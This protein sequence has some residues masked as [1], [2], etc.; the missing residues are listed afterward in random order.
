MP[1]TSFVSNLIPKDVQGDYFYHF[2]GRSVFVSKGQF[3]YPINIDFRSTPIEIKYKNV[4]F[5]RD[6]IVEML[7]YL[8]PNSVKIYKGINANAFRGTIIINGDTQNYDDNL[9]FFII[10]GDQLIRLSL[11]SIPTINT[12]DRNIDED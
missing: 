11:Y 5:R 10:G 8:F 3:I 12:N 2:I 1:K 6:K 9:W 4:P 7:R